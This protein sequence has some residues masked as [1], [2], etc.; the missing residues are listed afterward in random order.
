MDAVAVAWTRARVSSWHNLSA[1][2][3]WEG[4]HQGGD[5]TASRERSSPSTTPSTWPWPQP[6]PNHRLARKPTRFP[7]SRAI[8]LG[9]IL[10]TRSA[11]FNTLTR[12][13]THPKKLVTTRE[14]R[15]AQR[16][17]PFV[18]PA[19]RALQYPMAPWDYTVELHG[20]TREGATRYP[21]RPRL[22]PGP[23]LARAASHQA[24]HHRPHAAPQH[25]N[26]I[27]ATDTS[28]HRGE[29][30]PPSQILPRKEPEPPV[31]ASHENDARAT[32]HHY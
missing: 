15:H 19:R 2:Q 21:A 13:T 6:T 27:D 10:S 26:I 16:T 5:H 30:P 4:R 12:P 1:T 8:A 9:Q 31:S 3:T 32:P 25:Q 28:H 22:A 18:M 23:D 24:P 7:P 17:W 29:P 20:I 14:A 11:K